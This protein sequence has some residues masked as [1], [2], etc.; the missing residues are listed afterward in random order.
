MYTLSKHVNEMINTLPHEDNS[1]NI[2]MRRLKQ[3]LIPITASDVI[4]DVA[5]NPAMQ[6]I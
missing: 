1:D 3:V 4:S 6:G 2:T 5:L